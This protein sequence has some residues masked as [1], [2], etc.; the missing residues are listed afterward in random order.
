MG[1]TFKPDH[2]TKTA[3][4]GASTLQER[5][6]NGDFNPKSPEGKVLTVEKDS[7]SASSGKIHLCVF[8]IG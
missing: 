3:E 1:M 2:P 8:Q 7:F 6:N 5:I 4:E